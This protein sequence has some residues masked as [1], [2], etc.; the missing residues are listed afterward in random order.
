M[1][2]GCHRKSHGSWEFLLFFHVDQGT[3]HGQNCLVLI[4][5]SIGSL[6]Q[7][8]IIALVPNCS[9]QIIKI[10]QMVY[11]YLSFDG[12]DLAVTTWFHRLDVDPTQNDFPL[13]EFI[14]VNECWGYRLL[15][16]IPSHGDMVTWWAMKLPSGLT[17]LQEADNPGVVWT[18]QHALKAKILRFSECQQLHL[19]LD[20]QLNITSMFIFILQGIRKKLHSRHHFPCIMDRT[21]LGMSPGASWGVRDPHLW[22]RSLRWPAE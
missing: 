20:L 17:A 15:T 10:C 4:L 6:Q 18:L 13:I 19:E 7:N 2:Y 8:S 3:S 1:V 9:G 22:D 21:S 16:Q 11:S 12:S 5:F 14:V